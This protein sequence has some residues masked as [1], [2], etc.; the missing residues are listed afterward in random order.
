[1]P[2]WSDVPLA[3]LLSNKSGLPSIIENSLDGEVFTLRVSGPVGPDYTVLASPDLVSWAP[4][5]TTNS[6]AV[7]FSRAFTNGVRPGTAE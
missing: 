4:V 1:M 3:A 6:P 5:F 2:G 7:P